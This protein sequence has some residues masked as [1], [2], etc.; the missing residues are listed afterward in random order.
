[1]TTTAAAAVVARRRL[2]LLVLS[3]PSGV[4]KSF[5][6]R[7]LQKTANLHP[8]VAAPRA[9][10]HEF[11]FEPVQLAVSHTTRE[12]RVGEEDGT[13]Y[14]FVS[15][16]QFRKNLA[17]GAFVEHA[18][19]HGNW[20]GT[21]WQT[22]VSP[23]AGETPAGSSGG[24]SVL[25]VDVQGAASIRTTLQDAVVDM[26]ACLGEGSGSG[27]G[28]APDIPIQIPSF[29]N[30]SI[31]VANAMENIV[32]S[33]RFLFIAPSSLV[34]LEKRLRGRGS[35]SEE[36]I[37]R[38]LR[39]AEKEMRL[40]SANSIRAVRATSGSI[41][42]IDSDGIFSDELFDLVVTRG[43]SKWEDEDPDTGSLATI[44]KFLETSFPRVEM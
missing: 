12:K 15:R 8:F 40:A 23:L 19:V 13:H 42:D 9:L 39:T 4:G 16:E 18:E 17:R 31:S 6:I 30:S 27:R 21:S 37:L 38:R 1:M 29:S 34:A 36:S 14:H 28:L 24:L 26:G 5:L 41:A 3:G 22:L 44:I 20:Y 32:V 35:D 33:P 2:R 7:L 25:D 43:D 11:A 10:R